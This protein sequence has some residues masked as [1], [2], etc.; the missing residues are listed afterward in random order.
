MGEDTK[1]KE[2]VDETTLEEDFNKA[3]EDLS[4]SLEIDEDLEKAKKSKKPVPDEE[5]DNEPES[6]GSDEEGSVDED[7]EEEKDKKVKKSL[8]DWMEDDEDAEAAMDVEPFL[9]QLVKSLTGVLEETRAGQ[10]AKIAK[11]E[12]L[13]KSQGRLLTVQAK[14][15]KSVA[16]KTEKIANT[17]MPVQ[18]VRQLQK[19]RFAE[20]LPEMTGMQV[21]TKS[22]NWLRDNKITL[23]EA[24]KIEG[25]VNSGSLG[26]QKDA[27]D[28][29]VTSLLKEVK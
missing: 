1:K 14:L 11:L 17:P 5:D 28:I 22:R 27:L 19:G 13:V 2:A 3:L 16:E 4:K 18:S 20:D 23:L 25:R 7:E 9:R 24:G 10:E 12:K 15:Q 29:K 8:D 26:Q 21:L 6:D